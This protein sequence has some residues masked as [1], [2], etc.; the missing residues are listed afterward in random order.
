MALFMARDDMSVAHLLLVGAKGDGTYQR[1]G[2]TRTFVD[3]EENST[4]PFLRD[5][6]RTVYRI[7]LLA[8]S[9]LTVARA[10]CQGLVYLTWRLQDT[11][12][13]LG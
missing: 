11:Y 5:S 8:W 7:V 3:Q 2:I 1:I 12:K 6:A 4:Q 10:F 9:L 13:R